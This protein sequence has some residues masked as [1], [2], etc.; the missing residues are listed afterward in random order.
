LLWLLPLQ[1]LRAVIKVIV[2]ANG[3]V[4]IKILAIA[5]NAIPHTVGIDVGM[6]SR[7]NQ[8]SNKKDN[9]AAGNH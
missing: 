5:A 3:S 9:T 7:W 4:Q 8:A 6:M 2:Q 1:F